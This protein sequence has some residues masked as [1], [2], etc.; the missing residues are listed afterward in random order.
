M[1]FELWQTSESAYAVQMIYNNKAMRPQECQA[2]TC[3]FDQFQNM[4][5]SRLTIHD[6]RRECLAQSEEPV[7][8]LPIMKMT[9]WTEQ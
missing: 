3:P 9:Y 8:E 7:E 2:D 5:K 1:R 6:V 4:I